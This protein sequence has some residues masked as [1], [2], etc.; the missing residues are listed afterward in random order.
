M[1]ECRILHDGKYRLARCTALD[2]TAPRGGRAQ[3]PWRGLNA[4]A[5]SGVFFS[6]SLSL[7]LFFFFPPFRIADGRLTFRKIFQKP[8]CTGNGLSITHPVPF[9]LS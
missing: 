2:A 5:K 4:S 1:R 8:S 7:S 3:F 9:A 6:L